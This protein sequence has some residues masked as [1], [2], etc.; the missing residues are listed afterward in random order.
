MVCV[1]GMFSVWGVLLGAFLVTIL[2]EIL[3]TIIPLLFRGAATSQFEMILYGI[4]LIVVIIYMPDG[5]IGWLSRL[6]Q[7]PWL[8]KLRIRLSPQETIK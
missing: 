5:L 7:K 3:R 6:S 2:M 8:R 4:G 1:G